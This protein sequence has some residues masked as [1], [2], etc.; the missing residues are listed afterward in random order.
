MGDAE[1]FDCL[2]SHNS[3]DEP[4]VMGLATPRPGIR[5]PDRNARGHGWRGP[6]AWRPRQEREAQ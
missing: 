4:A 2:L 5:R 6:F 1:T 3:K